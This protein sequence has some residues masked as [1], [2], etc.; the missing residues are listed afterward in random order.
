MRK[1]VLFAMI[2]MLFL[3]SCT[4]EQIEERKIK[5]R[6][7]IA[8]YELDLNN[9]QGCQNTV[10]GISFSVKD[11]GMVV[12]TGKKAIDGPDKAGT[13]RPF[14][15]YFDFEYETTDIFGTKI[16]E[17]ERRYFAYDVFE[18]KSGGI[19]TLFSRIF[20][21]GV[22]W[23]LSMTREGGNVKSISYTRLTG[24]YRATYSLEVK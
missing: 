16:A 13:K 18:G 21:D 20:I 4:K 23:D 17:S 5:G 12:F 24:C 9:I 14:Y 11:P 22:D 10:S 1:Q 7:K 6:Y 15:G 3:F 19:D 8:N 2:G